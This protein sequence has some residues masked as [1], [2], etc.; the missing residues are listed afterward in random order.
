MPIPD[1]LSLAP[2]V[3]VDVAL[4]K[5]TLAFAFASGV[6]ETAFPQTLLGAAPPASTWEPKTFVK[7]LFVAEFVASLA[8]VIENRP[9]PLDQKNLTR[10]LSSPPQD[11]AVSEFR[12][13]IL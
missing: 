4:M 13:M 9:L 11:T 2:S 6:P 1:L 5:Q 12:R 7:A 10:V 8:V 3:R